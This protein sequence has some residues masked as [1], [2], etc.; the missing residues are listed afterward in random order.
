MSLERVSLPFTRRTALKVLGAAGLASSVAI[1]GLAPE[2]GLGQSVTPALGIP[3]PEEKVAQTLERL[4]GRRPLQPA[5]DKVKLEAPQ[6]AENG[7]VVPVSVEA[8]LP[9]T[10]DNYVKHVYIIADKNRRPLNAKLTLTPESGKAAAGT[11]IRL[12]STSDVRA[13]VEMSGGALYEA[14]TEVKV[15]VGGCGG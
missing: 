4:F 12:A 13:I 14:K 9:M 1:L 3:Q 7:S 8:N 11:R 6:I 5:G 2:T 10:P 15:T